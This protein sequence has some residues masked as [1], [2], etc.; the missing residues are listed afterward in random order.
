MKSSIMAVLAFLVLLLSA[1]AWAQSDG[2]Q[3][4]Q[5]PKRYVSAEGLNHTQASP[6]VSEEVQKWKEIGQ[7]IGVTFKEALNSAV[8]AADRFG[9]TKVGTFIMVMVAW[10][11]I[12]KDLAGILLGIPFLIA[13][14]FLFIYLLRRLFLGYRV[15]KRAG[16]F[17]REYEEHA[18]YKF[19]SNDS[20]TVAAALVGV[21]YCV[22]VL[23]ML[24][25]IFP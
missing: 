18:P 19:N 11:I 17:T 22:F 15:A 5:V 24:I 6:Q 8:D 16:F 25:V 14:T 23:A 1:P 9:A 10:R 7:G 13:G 2:D 12:G 4:V 20:R 3:L 21:A